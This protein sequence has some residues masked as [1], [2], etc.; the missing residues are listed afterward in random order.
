M[1]DN[2][3]CCNQIYYRF[4]L[5][6]GMLHMAFFIPQFLLLVPVPFDKVSLPVL[7]LD[8]RLQSVQ[9]PVFIDDLIK[10]G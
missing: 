4:V 1:R 10:L 9:L 6:H 5:A 7:V 3:N 8:K 2:G